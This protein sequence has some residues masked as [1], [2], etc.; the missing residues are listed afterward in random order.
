MVSPLIART[1]AFIGISPALFFDLDISY[2][3]IFDWSAVFFDSMDAS[4]APHVRNEMDTE[5]VYAHMLHGSATIKA[6]AGKVVLLS[7]TEG[8]RYWV[9]D[10]YFN[11]EVYSIIETGFSLKNQ[12]LLGY[13]VSDK[14]IAL[15][16]NEFFHY[17]P[18]E[19]E[20]DSFGF[21]LLLDQVI[22]YSSFLCIT[23]YHLENPD[24]RGWKFL[25]ALISDFPLI[26]SKK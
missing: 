9:P 18:T 13:K 24:F 21:G 5:F 12:T 25:F 1:G 22:P 17:Y 23:A 7:I 20:K 6:A 2:F 4:Y 16:E 8:A 19:Y 10:K 15:I 14:L 26:S 11:I 3:S